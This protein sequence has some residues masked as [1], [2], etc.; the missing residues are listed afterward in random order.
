MCD[1]YRPSLLYDILVYRACLRLFPADN[2]ST[3]IYIITNVWCC[4]VHRWHVPR[5]IAQ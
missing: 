1:A 2:V 5:Q 4:S 3:Y